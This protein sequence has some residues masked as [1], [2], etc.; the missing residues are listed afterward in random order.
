MCTVL[1]PPRVRRRAIRGLTLL[2]VVVGLAILSLMAGAIYA[3]VMGSVEATATLQNIQTE[4]RRLEAVLEQ[5]RL[6]FANL[7]AG[8]TLELRRLENEPPRQELILRGVPTAFV[9][10]ERP[11]WDSGV[12]TLAPQP[13][14]EERLTAAANRASRFGPRGMD[15][16]T[17][18]ARP[19]TFALSV[20]DF[21]RTD[22]DGEPLPESPLQS[23]QGHQFLRPDTQGRFWFDLLPEVDRVEWKFYDPARKVWVD[24][25]PPGRPPMIEL[26]L[27]LPG[28]TT[29]VRTVFATA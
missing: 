26:L 7:P 14:P 21:F 29:P 16:A 19:F 27:T 8:A 11:R 6:A 3:I 12:I 25:H 2:E 5:T 15:P 18:A 13:W 24:Q 10:G 4:D 17:P 23:R 1:D 22:G 9:W 20:A 28:R